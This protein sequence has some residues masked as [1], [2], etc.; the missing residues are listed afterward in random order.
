MKFTNSP[1]VS[2]TNLSPNYSVRTRKIDTIT[3]HVVVGHTS[4]QTLGKFFANKSVNASSN[5][6]IDDN[7]KVGMFVEEKNRSWCTSSSSNDQRAVTIE[8]AS[9]VKHPYAITDG[10]MR[11]T[12]ALCADICKRNDIPELRWEGDK[13]LI[14]QIDKQNISVH[15]WFA[16]KACPGDYVYNRLGILVAEVNKIIKTVAKPPDS[17]FTV[18]VTAKVLNYR[19]GPGITYAVAGQVRKG[20][21]YT[22]VSID[23]GPGASKWGRLKSGAGWIS[24]DHCEKVR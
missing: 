8:I 7:G 5:Y 1:L 2:H 17:P 3:P 9:D 20:E 23:N 21:V 16:A 11:G 19:K 13:K 6:G 18:R 12:I 10:A 24:L 14:G 22:I 4:L 15:R